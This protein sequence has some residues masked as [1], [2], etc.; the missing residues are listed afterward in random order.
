MYCTN[1]ILKLGYLKVELPVI[2]YYLIAVKYILELYKSPVNRCY[3]RY[4]VL[5]LVDK[6]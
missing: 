6:S 5:L 4:H 3:A 1:N 2:A